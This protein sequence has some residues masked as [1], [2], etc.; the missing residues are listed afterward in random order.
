MA[1]PW[2]QFKRVDAPGNEWEQFARADAK[3]A[4]PSPRMDAFMGGLKDFAGKNLVLGGIRGAADIGET[5]QHALNPMAWGTD[6]KE[7]RKAGIEGA[8]DS[9]GAEKD[10]VLYGTGRLTTN[11]AGTVGVG[12]ALG[13][14]A[15]SLGAAPGVA[16]AL[17]SGGFTAG[18]AAPGAAWFAAHQI[19]RI[20]AGGAVGGASAA[21]VDSDSAG[22]GAMIGGA[23]PPAIRILGAGGATVASAYRKYIS[24]GM[25]A[26]QAMS[27]ALGLATPAQQAAA[28][29]VLREAESFV[30]GANTTVAQAMQTPS[31]SVL[32]KAVFDAAKPTSSLHQTLRVDQPAARAAALERVAPTVAAGRDTARADFGNALG[33]YATDAD[34]AARAGTSKIY[35]SIPQDEAALYLPDLGAVRDQYFGRGSFGGRAAADQ[36]V[37]TAEQIGF[38]EIP[39]IGAIKEAPQ[40]SLLDA[41]KR[42]GGINQGTVSS[43]LLGGEVAALRES[44]LGRVVYKGRGQSVAKMAEKMHEA[45]YI[46]NEDPATLIDMLRGQGKS[47]FSD[48]ADLSSNYRAAAEAAMGDAPGA[49]RVPQKVTLREFEDLRKSISGAARGAKLD[50][51]RATEALALNKM[52]ESLGDRIN[53]VVR[54]DGA[55]DENLPIAWADALDA[56]RKSKV[57]QVARYRTGPQADIFKM[58]AD[59]QPKLQGGEIPGK[60]WHMG[61]AADK[62]VKSFRRL[63]DDNPAM[64]GQFRSMIT[65]D[66]LGKEAG[67]NSPMLGD[68]FA[69][70]VQQNMP[71]LREAFDQKEVDMLTRIA[72]DIT[73]NTEAVRLGGARAGS[74]TVQ[75]AANALSNGWLDSPALAGAV[76]RVPVVGRFGNMGLGAA[77]SSLKSSKANALAELLADSGKA[78]NALDDLVRSGQATPA[79]ANALLNLLG[80]SSARALPVALSR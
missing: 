10:S 13:A 52:K 5:L 64:L 27:K 21:L 42:A 16:N 31:A 28:A 51:E 4:A 33:K 45:G 25:G 72:K 38:S 12:G 49:A 80:Q 35:Q 40:L 11:I 62:D 2:D 8:M 44:G 68:T 15:K 14:G 57:E 61:G 54:G 20:G 1:D 7:K 78:A 71:G 23:L 70:W 55:L 50:P 79:E 67:K 26:A 32:E 30:P 34:A 65:T 17:T 22:A 59:G 39:A 69:K 75:K 77:Q 74:D 76:S 3:P 18:R 53:T 47:T 63:V 60:F 48:Y 66:G 19:G 73:R 36:A 6:A 58:G 46:P 24:D 43:Q 37:K 29:K 56:A 9:L 41:V